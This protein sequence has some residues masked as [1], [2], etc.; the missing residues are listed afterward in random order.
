MQMS[1][2]AEVIGGQ[3]KKGGKRWRLVFT[4][5]PYCSHIRR[6]TAC[7][8]HHLSP[9]AMFGVS[10]LLTW[11]AAVQKEADGSM[12]VRKQSTRLPRVRK[13]VVST[14]PFLPSR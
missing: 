1:S 10:S 8:L 11:S 3:G 6:I 4:A 7:L 5:G 12:Q 14:F 13:L 9:Q 2:L